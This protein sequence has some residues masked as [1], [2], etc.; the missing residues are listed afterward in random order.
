MIRSQDFLK[1]R[2]SSVVVAADLVLEPGESLPSR[3]TASAPH[4]G[5]SIDTFI[6]SA[7]FRQTYS[8]SP[9]GQAFRFQLPCNLAA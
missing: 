8:M 6:I 5:S 1:Q 3:I 4:T 9:M 2:K 7:W